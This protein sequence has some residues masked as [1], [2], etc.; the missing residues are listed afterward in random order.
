MTGLLDLI[1]E[2]KR[3]ERTVELCLRG[4]LVGE[5]GALERG[6]VSALQRQADSF[7]SPGPAGSVTRMEELRLQMRAA[8]VTFHLGS[9]GLERSADL[10]AGHPPRDGDK[11][12]GAN[13]YNARTFYPAL[14]RATCY[15]ITGPGDDLILHGDD[16]RPNDAMSE[17]DWGEPAGSDYPGSGLLGQLNTR[18][19]QRL[20][21][22]AW[23]VDHQEVEVPF[24]PLAFVTSQR[25]GERSKSQE[26]GESAPVSSPASPAKK[27]RRTS[28]TKKAA[29]SGQ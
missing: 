15:K 26:P 12:D 9:I 8:T 22:E 1:R 17:A 2:A 13:G 4:D 18:D 19:Y 14:I 24:S 5:Y 16:G 11:R 28:T 7:D 25:D 21:D 27:S 23:A 29:S 6:F 20:R 3:P 10:M